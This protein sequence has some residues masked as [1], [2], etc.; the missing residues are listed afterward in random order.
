M[1]RSVSGLNN[2][3]LYRKRAFDRANQRASRA[4]KKNR[5]QE[6]EEEVAE[7]QQK[8]E[9]SEE[10]VRRLQRSDTCLREIIDSARASL[11]MVE[12]H[13]RS[14]VDEVGYAQPTSSAPG[15]LLDEAM[16]GPPPAP[17]SP[18]PEIVRT[19]GQA[20]RMANSTPGDD[21][22]PSEMSLRPPSLEQAEAV[23][24]RDSD[25]G[26]SLDLPFDADNPMLDIWGE[27]SCKL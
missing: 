16:H 19:S 11:Q 3:Q 13:Q 21:T 5:I 9:R 14:P 18:E 7:L 27:G 24:L 8:L 22:M 1:D 10:L 2:E 6:L 20:E 4:R 15:S 23:T 12:H 25:T 26:L 17:T